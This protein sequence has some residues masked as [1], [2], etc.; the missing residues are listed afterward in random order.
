MNALIGT[1]K[2]AI[3][4]R[5]A[6]VIALSMLTSSPAGERGTPHSSTNA[7]VCYVIDGQ[8]YCIP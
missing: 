3:L 4:F 8:I 1:R 5:L 6:I 2:A 7:T